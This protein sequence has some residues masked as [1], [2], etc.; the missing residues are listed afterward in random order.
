MRHESTTAAGYGTIP[1]Q[2]EAPPLQEPLQSHGNLAAT[3][4]TDPQ[5]TRTTNGEII[6]ITAEA[7]PPKLIASLRLRGNKDRTQS[8]ASTLFFFSIG[9]A[10][11]VHYLPSALSFCID[12]AILPIQALSSLAAIASIGTFIHTRNNEQLTV[13]N[14]PTGIPFNNYQLS[15]KTHCLNLNDAA[16]L[17]FGLCAGSSLTASLFC[18]LLTASGINQQFTNSQNTLTGL[19][20]I[21]CFLFAFVSGLIAVLFGAASKCTYNWNPMKLSNLTD[22]TTVGVEEQFNTRHIVQGRPVV[23]TPSTPSIPNNLP[24]HYTW[25]STPPPHPNDR[26]EFEPGL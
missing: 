23:E 1:G 20:A 15:P 25:S 2:P 18:I 3:I 17:A 8:I 24:W 9:A 4:G 5:E 12:N 22:L 16:R 6:H 14:E 21:P 19:S 11:S 13:I 7:I 26:N 10:I